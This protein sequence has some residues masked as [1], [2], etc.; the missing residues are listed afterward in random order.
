MST[1]QDGIL[2]INDLGGMRNICSNSTFLTYGNSE[3]AK[4]EWCH[5]LFCNKDDA[6]KAV[7]HESNEYC[8]DT[9]Y[10]LMSTYCALY[11]PSS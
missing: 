9:A 5:L 6:R 2:G 11:V 4:M 7:S 3:F 8:I 10:I 1:M